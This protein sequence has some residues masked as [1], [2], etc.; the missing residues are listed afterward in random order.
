M[1]IS[2]YMS[3]CGAQIFEAIGLQAT[4]SR[5]TSRHGPPRSGHRRV[6]GRRGSHPQPHR[7][8]RRRPGAATMLDAGGEYAWRMPRRRAHVDAGRDRRSCSTARAQ[9]VRGPTR[10]TPDHQ[11]PEPP[12]PDAARPVRVQGWT[13]Q[14]HSPDEVEPAR[15][16]SASPPARC[17]SARSP[18]KPTHAGAGDEPHRRQVN[19][20][21]GGEDRAR[22]RNASRAFPSRPAPRCRT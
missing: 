5:S 7:G 8:L 4:S 21:E 15:S 11:R 19:T 12:P 3:Y 2:T 1:G 13:D 20:G 16:S 6:R 10:N 18:P 17:R 9:Q 14:G 22:Y